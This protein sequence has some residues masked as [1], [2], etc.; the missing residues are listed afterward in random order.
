MK[1]T[2]KI[3]VVM[4]VVGA[5]TSLAGADVA[6]N[7]T[8]TAGGGTGGEDVY[9]FILTFD[10]ADGEFTNAR[11]AVQMD[12]A[13]IQDPAPGDTTGGSAVSVDT[14]VSTVFDYHFDTGTS[15]IYNA[16]DPVSPPPPYDAPPVALLDWDFY[17]NYASDNSAYSPSHI[18]RVLVDAGAI[19]AAMVRVWT[20]SDP[21][22]PVEFN[23][24][25]PEPATMV[26]L[27]IGGIGVLLRRKRR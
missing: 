4:V 15:M 5:M 11:L 3:A 6:V 12:A 13:T 22:V 21:G 17:D 7:M 16:Y 9:D 1:T 25:I 18:A 19:G 27:G 2:M 26:L 14:W 23:F 24:D 10:S 20:T 8:R